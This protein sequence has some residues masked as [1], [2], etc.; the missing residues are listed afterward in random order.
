MQPQLRG[1]MSGLKQTLFR[2]GELIDRL[3]KLEKLGP[4]TRTVRALADLEG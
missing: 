1:L 4:G 3:L 2:M